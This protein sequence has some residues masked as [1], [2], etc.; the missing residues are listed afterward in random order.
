M[1]PTSRGVGNEL[2]QVRRGG[3]PRDEPRGFYGI[4][5]EPPRPVGARLLGIGR[6]DFEVGF[7]TDR[8]ERI[9]RASSDVLPAGRRGDAESALDLRARG[10]QIGSRVHEV[11]DALEHFGVKLLGR[12]TAARDAPAPLF[13]LH[14]PRLTAS[15]IPSLQQRRVRPPE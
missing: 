8:D 1:N 2:R 10:V 14:V 5:V 15:S 13:G 12:G 7:R 4:D 6:D 3:G 9:A 11:V